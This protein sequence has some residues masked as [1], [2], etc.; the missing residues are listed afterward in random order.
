MSTSTDLF[1]IP[2]NTRFLRALSRAGFTTIEQVES[3]PDWKLQ[4]V[5]GLGRHG[6][7][8]VR[9][10]VADYRK[11]H[12]PDVTSVVFTPSLR[13]LLAGFALAGVL[14]RSK[15][16]P[17]TNAREAKQNADALL[18]LLKAGGAA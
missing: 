17:E 14:S 9:N 13:T 3:A 16:D 15:A 1:S 5:R 10:A 11:E 6:L 7:H 18:A 8:M 12:K 4:E 2:T